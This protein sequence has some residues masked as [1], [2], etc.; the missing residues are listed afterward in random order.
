MPKKLKAIKNWDEIPDMMEPQ[1]Y[2]DVMGCSVKTA[3]EKFNS[4][5]FP[6]ITNGRVNKYEVM[7]F[8]GIKNNDSNES[9][10]LALL[11]EMQKDIKELKQEQTRKLELLKQVI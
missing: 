5:G 9:A 11:I 4:R 10:V 3:R 1:D 8:L 2:A 6:K 7:K